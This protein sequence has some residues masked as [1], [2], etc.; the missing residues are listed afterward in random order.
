MYVI[1]TCTSITQ[2]RV[3]EQCVL[4][5]CLTGHFTS[6]LF[7]SKPSNQIRGSSAKNAKK[8]IKKLGKETKNTISLLVGILLEYHW[9]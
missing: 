8:V 1:Y 6:I 3:I 4:A 5:G 7:G 9:K 2:S